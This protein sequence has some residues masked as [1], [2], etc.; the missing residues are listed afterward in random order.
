MEGGAKDRDSLNFRFFMV[1][2]K[3]KILVEL[4]MATC[5]CLRSHPP[6]RL[7][8]QAESPPIT[9][10]ST[11][12]RPCVSASPSVLRGIKE[13]RNHPSRRFKRQ[14]SEEAGSE[15][16]QRSEFRE[17]KNV[18]QRSK[19]KKRKAE[20]LRHQLPVVNSLLSCA[21]GTVLVRNHPGQ[22]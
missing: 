6:C 22:S 2:Q 11:P 3:K 1:N 15:G 19:K 5:V 21:P 13:R 20:A 4:Q 12:P 17:W 14:G 9:N 18:S 7:S 10:E 16:N 8:N